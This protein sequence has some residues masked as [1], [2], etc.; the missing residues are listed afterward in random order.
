MKKRRRSARTGEGVREVRGTDPQILPED[1]FHALIRYERRR[2]DRTNSVFSLIAFEVDVSRA[3]QVERVARALRARARSVDEIGW[4][5]AGRLAV[6]LP[7]TGL[8]GAWRFAVQAEERMMDRFE[9][10]PFTVYAYPDHWRE[11]WSRPEEDGGRQSPHGRFSDLSRS[12]SQRGAADAARAVQGRVRELL[13]RPVPGWKRMQDVAGSLVFL[14]LLSPLLLLIAL[15]VKLVSPGP[16]LFR[17][18]RIGYRGVPFS[19][20]KFRTMRANTSPVSHQS[21]LHELIHSDRPMRKLDRTRDPRIIPGGGLLRKASLDELPQL[22]NVLRGEMSLVGPRPCLPYEAR[23]YDRWHAQRFDTL[24]GMTGLWQVSGKNRLT[25][26][27]MIRMDIEYCRRM[28]LLYDLKILALTVPTVIGLL[29]EGT[30]EK[31]ARR[32]AAPAAE[33]PPEEGESYP[34]CR[35]IESIAEKYPQGGLE[36]A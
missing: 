21:H 16:V 15:Y 31:L 13:S 3:G 18:K 35:I 24:P 7:A 5:E 28:S 20:L 25:F 22:I 14:I 12:F 27:Q 11:G 26:R 29:F 10:P 34:I 6:L 2:V 4:L 23:E 33:V 32:R 19:F 30:L 1:M 9:P 8:E 17:Q 36:H